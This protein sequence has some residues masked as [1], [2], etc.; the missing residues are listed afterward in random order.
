MQ[1]ILLTLLLCYTCAAQ[2]QPLTKA[3]QAFQSGDFD[4]AVLE[5]QATLTTPN[6][7]QRLAA[8]LGIIKASQ[9]LGHYDKALKTLDTA[10]P[11][12]KQIS[13]AAYHVLLLNEQSKIS[14]SQGERHYETAFEQAEAT[15]E[16]AKKLNNPLVLVEVLRHWGNMLTVEY[17]FEEAIEAYREALEK[18]PELAASTSKLK[19]DT[20]PFSKAEIEALEGKILI[21]LAQTNFLLDQEE[22]QSFENTLSILDDALKATQ[23]WQPATYTRILALLTLSQIAHKIQKQSDEAAAQSMR[24]AYQALKNAQKMARQL[25]NI[26]TKAFTYGQLGQLYQQTKRYQ[27]ALSLTRQAIFFAQQTRQ[28]SFLY[29]WQWQLAR[30]QT[31]LG[32]KEGAITSYRQ[33]IGNF[34]NVHAQVATTGYASITETFREK[35]APIYFE[36]ADLLLQKARHTPAG[37]ARQALLREARK[38]VEIYKEAELQNYFQ[39]DCMTLNEDCVDFKHVLDAQTAILYPIPL[40]D[41]LEM[42]LE[43]QDGLVQATVPVSEKQLRGQIAALLMPLRNHPNLEALSRSRSQRAAQ[44]QELDEEICRPMLRGSQPQKIEGPANAFWGPAQ[45]LYRWLIEPFTTQLAGIKTLVIVP[46]GSLRTIPFSALH[47]GQKFLIQKYALSTLPGLCLKESQTVQAQEEKTLLSGLSKPVLGFSPLPCAQFEVETLQT[48]LDNTPKPLFN[49][50][51]TFPNVESDITKTNYS[52]MHIASHGQFSGTLEKTFVLMYEDKLTMD[53]LEL[54][55]ALTTVGDKQPLDLLTLSACE[56]AVGDDR[57]ALG[58]AGVALKAGALT[59]LASLWKVDDEATPAVVIE[60][61]RQL[62]KGI[63]K[64]KALQT[65]QNLIL[66][67]NNYVRYRHPYFWS[68][69]IL[70]GQW[71]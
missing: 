7:E 54:L 45:T 36:L 23:K 17:D 57:A 39:T 20:L 14:L 64:A 8:W 29:F 42:L 67:D 15:L 70:I 58:L 30:I 28:Q 12:A 24:F 68:A 3:Q 65:A 40:A 10:L 32:H 56:T 52:V 4:R 71:F 60:F 18:I 22:A 21:S 31:A 69:F 25:N 49:E 34:Q 46:D 43:R 13:N 37:S 5:W 66:T 27:E 53:R 44:A 11:I 26:S 6:T 61:Y 33:A 50:K 41:R 51:F 1:K 63:T 35:V 2:A 47:D 9:R 55:V 38:T 19:G 62:Q 48:L 16:Q 59:A